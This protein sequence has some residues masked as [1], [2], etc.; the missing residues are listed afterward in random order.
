MKKQL[1]I[2]AMAVILATFTGC[3]KD[4]TLDTSV[5]V[6]GNKTS[7]TTTVKNGT[8]SVIGTTANGTTANGSIAN[9]QAANANVRLFGGYVSTESDALNLRSEPNT[10]ASIIAQIPSGTQVN[11]YA[12]DTNGWYKVDFAGK[13]G[14]ASAEFIKEI[15]T[16]SNFL[17][18]ANKYGYYPVSE[19]PQTSISVGD[20][21]GTWHDGD[22][23]LTFYN[24]NWS[25]GEFDMYKTGAYT[26]G[27]VRL[28]YSVNPDGTHNMWYNLYDNS[29]EFVIGFRTESGIQL[30]DI[31]AGQSGFP[32]YT[33]PLEPDFSNT[34]EGVEAS[35]YVGTWGCD[36]CLVTISNNGGG[37]MANI[38]WASGV[39]ATLKHTRWTYDLTYDD[40]Q[41]IMVCYDG[42]VCVEREDYGDGTY[43]ETTR[44]TDGGATFAMR[45]GTLRWLDHK[46]DAAN[47][48]IFYK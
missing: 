34:A 43:T 44:Y 14:Y 48:M 36:R 7:T 6:A 20:L 38:E 29:N 5:T 15:E 2:I 32:H 25:S 27:I 47:G 42:G 46:E 3:G 24:C 18:T 22:D 4:A 11:V 17:D 13:I 26:H 40:R 31:Y 21:T 30:T 33:R 16:D 28:E 8:T 9:S 12:C 19:Q 45:E 1:V 35:D 39:G 37:Y 10:N 41:A 23:T